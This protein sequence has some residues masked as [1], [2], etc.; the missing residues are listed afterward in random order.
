M[1]LQLAVALCAEPSTLRKAVLGARLQRT[2]LRNY[3][4]IEQEPALFSLINMFVNE[5][6]SNGNHSL[7]IKIV[8]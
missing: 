3:Q 4:Y 5:S 8:Y 1:L 6:D 2:A 7:H